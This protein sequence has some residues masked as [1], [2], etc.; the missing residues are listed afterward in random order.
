M[1]VRVMPIAV[2]PINVW[3]NVVLFK[4]KFGVL[5]TTQF[6]KKKKTADKFVNDVDM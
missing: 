1:A 5:N 2:A 4:V 6:K 3:G